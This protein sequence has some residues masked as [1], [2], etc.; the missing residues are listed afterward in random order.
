MR[1]FPLPFKDSAHQKR[2][3]KT[4][5]FK[6]IFFPL[7]KDNSSNYKRLLIIKTGQ[8]F[9]RET[10]FQ[11]IKLCPQQYQTFETP[12]INMVGLTKLNRS[13]FLLRSISFLYI[14]NPS[15]NTLKKSVKF[16]LTTVFGFTIFKMLCKNGCER[17]TSYA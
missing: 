11:Q 14:L 5:H 12:K 3:K 8:V 4:E 2:K 7:I 15:S 10:E 9:I 13:I 16:Q 17:N 6:V 1:G